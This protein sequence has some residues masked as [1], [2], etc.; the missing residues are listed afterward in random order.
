MNS[1]R[2]FN[3]SRVI[4]TGHT[5]FKGSWL[6]AWLKLLNAKVMGISL[7]PPTKPSNFY[8]SG[9]NFG[10][11]DVRL[12]I[13]NR[14]KLE[15]TIIQFRPNFIFHLAAQSLVGTSYNNP[16]LTWE[17]NVLG[18]LNVLDSLRKLKHSCTAVIITSD[19]CYFNKE[20]HYGYKESDKLGGRDPYSSSKAAVEILVNSWRFSFVGN[21]PHQTDKLSIVTARSGNVIGGG[22]WAENRIVPDFVKAAKKEQ[23]LEIRNPQ[24]VRPWQHVLD[25]LNG[26]ILLAEELFNYEDDFK[27]KEALM[28]C[29]NFGPNPENHKTVLDLV[30][31]CKQFWPCSIKICEN[32]KKTYESKLLTLD[33]KSSSPILSFL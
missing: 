29:F 11:K 9:V 7:N 18:T 16:S 27:N 19:K 10:I 17:T 26:Y 21:L 4:V 1:F 15:K 33:S 13:R 23:N 3:N 28:S 24:S 14:K 22:D 25:T 8:A 31:I 2:I 5:G 12:D 30:N 6:T 32:N 20:V